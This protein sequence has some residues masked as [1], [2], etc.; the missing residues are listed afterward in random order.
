MLEQTLARHPFSLIPFSFPARP[1][2]TPTT[3]TAKATAKTTCAAAPPPR[4][5]ATDIT[6]YPKSLCP[7][8]EYAGHLIMERIP[9]PDL[10]RLYR[11][12]FLPTNFITK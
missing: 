7:V 11:M 8:G 6:L 9:V 3:T 2:P 4:N 1:C 5:A 12:A 10:R